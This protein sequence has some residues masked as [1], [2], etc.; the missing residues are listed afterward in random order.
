MHLFDGKEQSTLK[1]PRSHYGGECLRVLLNRVIGE[2][3]SDLT[4][5]IGTKTAGYSTS[6]S[7][8]NGTYRVPSFTF[9]A[10]FFVG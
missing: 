7:T 9:R 4:E 3:V 1:V 10:P 5:P 8:Q 6:I 2:S